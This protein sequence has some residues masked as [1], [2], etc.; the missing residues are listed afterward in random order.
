MLS[1]GDT[2]FHTPICS[3]IFSSSAMAASHDVLSLDANASLQVTGAPEPM[4]TFIEMSKSKLS[5][6]SISF[7]IEESE[8]L[9]ISID[10]IIAVFV[11][12]PSILPTS[13]KI[14]DA[15]CLGPKK[16]NLWRPGQHQ[17]EST[18]MTWIPN[19]SCANDYEHKKHNQKCKE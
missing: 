10:L 18:S 19:I 15:P 6:P 7:I 16:A 5:F 3:R 9:V 14:T 13:S 11:L 4:L 1:R 17:D 12:H 2:S 8:I